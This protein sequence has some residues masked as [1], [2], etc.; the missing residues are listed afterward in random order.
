ME[1]RNMNERLRFDDLGDALDYL[2]KKGFRHEFHLSEGLVAHSSKKENYGKN[3]LYFCGY[4]QYT[5]GETDALHNIYAV[6]TDTG[7]QG[8]IVA[9][10]TGADDNPVDDFVKSLKVNKNNNLYKTLMS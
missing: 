10:H 4:V 3:Q 1:E 9:E 6:E 2:A 8:Y 7:F 5:D